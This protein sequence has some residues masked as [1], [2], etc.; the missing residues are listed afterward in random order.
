METNSKEKKINFIRTDETIH[1][2]YRPFSY[3][4]NSFNENYRSRKPDDFFVVFPNIEE[5]LSI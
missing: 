3:N 2:Y 1:R 5:F 4:I